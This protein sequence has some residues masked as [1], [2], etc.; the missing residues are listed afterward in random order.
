M[1]EMCAAGCDLF[2]L[3]REQN[4]YIQVVI[5]SVFTAHSLKNALL[6][7]YSDGPITGIGHDLPS[8]PVKLNFCTSGQA[9]SKEKT[10]RQIPVLRGAEMK[11]IDAFEAMLSDIQKQAEY[12]KEQI[13]Y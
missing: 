4:L 5:I 13:N 11:R 8:T 9:P 7:Q 2:L 12:E 3:I 10:V 6:W 1:P